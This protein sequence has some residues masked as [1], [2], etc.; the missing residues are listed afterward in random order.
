ME[1]P[2]RLAWAE[3]RP[4]MERFTR[5]GP[6]LVLNGGGNGGEFVGS[7]AGNTASLKGNVQIRY[8][9][10]L[11]NAAQSDSYAILRLLLGSKIHPGTLCSKACDEIIATAAKR[12]D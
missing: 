4:F 1:F 12:T 10:S 6:T 8:D 11:G 7:L 9:E 2:K 5:R 3:V